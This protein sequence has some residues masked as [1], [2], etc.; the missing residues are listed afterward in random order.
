ML[1][2]FAFAS[3]ASATTLDRPLALDELAAGSDLAVRGVVRD[4]HVDVRDGRIWT[5][6][7]VDDT[8]VRVLGGCIEDLCM[9]VVGAPELREGEPVLVFLHDDQITGFSQG[10]FRIEGDEGVRDPAVFARGE[11]APRVRLDA[12]RAAARGILR[13]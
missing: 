1:I 9:T 6:A 8:P 7:W 2:L 12:L 11:M 10:F 4:V 3:L 13:E 5:V